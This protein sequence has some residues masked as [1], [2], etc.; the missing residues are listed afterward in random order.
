[1]GT[2]LVIAC[3]FPEKLFLWC[4]AAWCILVFPAILRLTPKR[5][6]QSYEAENRLMFF[7]YLGSIPVA[8]LVMLAA[9]GW[10]R[11]YLS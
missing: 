3:F 5:W 10:R 6:W 2:Q 8:L 11:L 7:W 9:Q 1:L 4:A